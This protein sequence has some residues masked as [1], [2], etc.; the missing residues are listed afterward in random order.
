MRHPYP[1]LSLC[2]AA[3]LVAPNV[4]ASTAKLRIAR[5]TTPVATLEHVQVQ[6]SWQDGAETGDLRIH[7][8]RVDAAD[9]PA[10]GPADGRGAARA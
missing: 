5:L 3:A 7:A 2:I 10:V 4:Q 1:L 9:P 6:L 8:D